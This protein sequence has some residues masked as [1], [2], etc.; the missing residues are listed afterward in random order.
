V[1]AEDE[2]DR[3][4]AGIGLVNGRERLLH[5][6]GAAVVVG[7]DGETQGHAGRIAEWPA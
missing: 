3:E 4:A 2:V 5:V 6:L 1:A 7:G